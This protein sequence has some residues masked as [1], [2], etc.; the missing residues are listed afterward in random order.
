VSNEKQRLIIISGLSGA[1]KS[2]A[3]HTLEDLGF[4][5]IDNLPVNLLVELTKNFDNYLD[6]NH[7]QLAVGID[8][9]LPVTS[10][11]ILPSSIEG[12][13]N[14]GVQVQMVFLE[15]D[16]SILAKRFSETRRKHPLSSDKIALS[17]AINKE[18]NILSSLSDIS[19][20]KI[21]TSHTTVH[22]LRQLL[23]QQIS[24]FSNEKLSLQLLSFGYKHGLPYD[25]DFVFDV[26]VLPNPYWEKSLREFSGKDPAV[27]EFLSK[28]QPVNRMLD[29]I[30]SF[31]REWIPQFEAGNRSY[32][33]LAIGCTG[34]H[35]RSVFMV[36]HLAER[37]VDLGNHI[38]TH[39][40]L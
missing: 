17:E 16:N 30:E 27:I 5:C 31:L 11:N 1:G 8:A 35:H 7:M 14:N 33:T 32:M 6:K 19:D 10:L 18:R 24:G 37:L 40:D 4:Y 3:L 28:Q 15:A 26:R 25:A 12:L 38:I 39:R 20:L 29:Q 34:G 22:D 9:R 13:V 2:I 36:E 21:D 23:R